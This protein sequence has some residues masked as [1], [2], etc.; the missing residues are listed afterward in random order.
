[1]R[2]GP[3][4]A[5]FWPVLARFPGVLRRFEANPRPF[6]TQ[7]VLREGRAEVRGG[8]SGD[9]RREV[10]GRRLERPGGRGL[11]AHGERDEDLERLLD[12]LKLP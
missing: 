10:D 1:M 7:V 9:E 12:G 3:G 4:G 2:R 11:H 8:L 5:C 6:S